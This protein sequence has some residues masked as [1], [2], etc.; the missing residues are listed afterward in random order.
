MKRIPEGIRAF[1]FVLALFIV[2]MLIAVIWAEIGPDSSSRC[3]EINDVVE[4]ADPR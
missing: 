1:A 3:Q 4:C 2:A